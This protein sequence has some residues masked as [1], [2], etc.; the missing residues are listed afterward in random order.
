M[1]RPILA[2]ALA[3]IA[4]VNPSR[5]QDEKS[6]EPCCV[7]SFHVRADFLNWYLRRLNVPPLLTA[8]PTGSTGIIGDPGVDVIRGSERLDSRHDRYVGV[9]TLADDWF[10]D[11]R[12]FGVQ[13]DAFFLER[14]STHFTV[15]PGDVAVLAIPFFGVRA[16]QNLAYVVSG[17]NPQFGD[18]D[19]G[20]R[21]YSRMELFGQEANA[22]YN[23]ARC[24]TSEWNVFAGARFLQ[25][26]E[27]LDITSASTVLPARSTVLGLEDHFQT[28]DHFYGGQVGLNG[29][30]RWGRWSLEGKGAVALGADDQT[31]RNKGTRIL[32]TPQQRQ[33]SDFGLFVLP[34]NRG[35]FT[36]T[37][38]D[39][40]TEL[41][42]NVGFEVTRH[43]RLLAGYTLLTWDGPV[44]PGDQ[45]GPI[46]QSQ[47]KATGLLGPAAPLPRFHEETFWA[48]GVNAGLELSW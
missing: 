46:N 48:Q 2:L 28:F 33:V 29:T 35:E 36:R 39:V 4:F 10:G 14:D 5:A 27:R 31:I 13:L 24:A 44:R 8:G 16:Q 17:F 22:L 18:V 43:A 15:R 26:R 7:E 30:I 34:S 20:S 38:F 40:V 45:V 37:S 47:T 21:V 12:Q 25:L 23:L 1:R 19:G 32:Q 41:R 42:L 9:R 6:A 3:L 11:E